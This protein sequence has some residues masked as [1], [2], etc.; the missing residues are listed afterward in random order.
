ME[1]VAKCKGGSRL[2]EPSQRISARDGRANL[3]PCTT[4]A[5]AGATRRRGRGRGESEVVVVGSKK[6]AP[7]ARS[8][9]DAR[10]P[11][12]AHALSP[13]APPP[14]LLASHHD[15]PLRGRSLG[16]TLGD[17]SRRHLSATPSATS[18]RPLGD[19]PRDRAGAA[20]G[21]GRGLPCGHPLG[22]P[23]QPGV[24]ASRWIWRRPVRRPC[25][26]SRDT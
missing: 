16:D 26:L 21:W 10:A 6:E 14:S 23:P 5:P 4:P 22:I 18:R 11:R 20:R 24:R 3:D 12:G 8:L 13:R 9:I 7:R 15:R 19:T 17:T 25:H 2:A 1:G